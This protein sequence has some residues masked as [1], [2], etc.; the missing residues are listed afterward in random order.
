VVRREA[1]L[2]CELERF[3]SLVTLK[4]EAMFCSE[5]SVLTTATRCNISK[6]FHH[7]YSCENIPQYSG[8]R[9]YRKSFAYCS[10]AASH[11]DKH[12]RHCD[13]QDAQTACPNV[14][15][16]TLTSHVHIK[17][18]GH[19]EN[20]HETMKQKTTYCLFGD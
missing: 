18:Y 13:E 11:P 20:R 2:R 5:T 16:L 14:S 4:M 17:Y 10:S 7:C 9:A 8:L 6:G 1:H 15:P 19:L 12:Y 3:K